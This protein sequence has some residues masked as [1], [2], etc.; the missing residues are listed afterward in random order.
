MNNA[1]LI[2]QAQALEQQAIAAQA[3]GDTTTA[4]MAARGAAAIRGQIL[5]N[6]VKLGGLAAL[7]TILGY[8]GVRYVRRRRGRK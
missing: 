1:A 2:T 7:L 6:R 4:T 3:R 5:K 8:V